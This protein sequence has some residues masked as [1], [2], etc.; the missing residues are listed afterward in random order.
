VRGRV[1]ERGYYYKRGDGGGR[2][3]ERLMKR[4]KETKGWLNRARMKLTMEERS[5]KGT[6]GHVSA[7]D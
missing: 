4:K 1:S 7:S 6:S 2:E 5:I 3:E